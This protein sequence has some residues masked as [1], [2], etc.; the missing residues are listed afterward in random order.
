MTP[1]IE[2]RQTATF[3][4]VSA[5]TQGHLKQMLD[6]GV[7]WFVVDRSTTDLIS[8]APFATIRYENDSFFVL[9]LSISD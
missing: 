1:E 9:E 8:W 2:R 7:D 6:D 5:P 4:F 3:G